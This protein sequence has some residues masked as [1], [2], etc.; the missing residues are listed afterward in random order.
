MR[1]CPA[2]KS[3]LYISVTTP[4]SPSP[5]QSLPRKWFGLVIVSADCGVEISPKISGGRV[6]VLGFFLW[7]QLNSVT[8]LINLNLSFLN[9]K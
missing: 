2:A 3:Q 8:F 5:V 6:H 4:K 9:K 1:V 7:A